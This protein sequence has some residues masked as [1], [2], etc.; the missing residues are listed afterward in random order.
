MQ[1]YTSKV[2]ESRIFDNYFTTE[3]DV[4]VD[5]KVVFVRFRASHVRTDAR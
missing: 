1:Y 3:L 2:D 4:L 5:I